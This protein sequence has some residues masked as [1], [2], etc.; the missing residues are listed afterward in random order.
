MNSTGPQHFDSPLFL[1]LEIP[2]PLEHPSVLLANHIPASTHCKDLFK[3]G[4]H[5]K[6]ER[7]SKESGDALHHAGPFLENFHQIHR[8][9]GS[10]RC[11]RSCSHQPERNRV[12]CRLPTAT[13]L[14]QHERKSQCLNSEIR[15][16]DVVTNRQIAHTIWNHLFLRSLLHST[17]ATSFD[18]IMSWIDTGV[19]LPPKGPAPNVYVRVDLSVVAGGSTP[20]TTTLTLTPTTTSHTMD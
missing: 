8:L 1:D 15:L 5:G 13:P 9:D 2:P 3:G 6:P 18:S 11:S 10:K 14:P 20:T 7:S 19:P 12:H 4:S 17:L 16:R